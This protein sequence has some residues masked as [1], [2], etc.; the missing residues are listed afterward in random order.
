MSTFTVQAHYRHVVLANRPP[1]AGRRHPYLT[2][3][4]NRECMAA[5]CLAME[6]DTVGDM[7][8]GTGPVHTARLEGACMGAPTAVMVPMEE[9]WVTVDQ[10]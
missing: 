2:G 10:A 5:A 4:H 7:V 8:R 6:E 9:G 1:P 3:R